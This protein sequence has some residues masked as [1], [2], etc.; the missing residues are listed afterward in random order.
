MWVKI[1]I[2]GEGENQLVTSF[3]PQNSLGAMALN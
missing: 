1:S 2:A 3:D